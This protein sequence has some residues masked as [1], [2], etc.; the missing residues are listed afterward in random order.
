MTARGH[1]LTPQRVQVEARALEV[2]TEA[3]A[4]AVRCRSPGTLLAYQL[5]IGRTVNVVRGRSSMMQQV[6]VFSMAVDP[7]VSEELKHHWR[8]FVVLRAAVIVLGILA[9]GSVGIA[10][11]ASVLVFGWILV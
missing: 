7:R 3:H 2:A 9:L 11:I 1:V 6:A 8:E 5:R 4:A 10:T